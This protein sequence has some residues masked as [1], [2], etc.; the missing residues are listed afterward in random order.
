MAPPAKR[1]RGLTLPGYKYLGPG[2]SL[3]QGEP[4]NPSDAAA[5]EHDE[6]YDKYIKS[7]KNPYFYFSAADEKFIKETEHAK[8]YGGKI[9]H[10][11]FRAKRA[12]APK[13]SETDSPT[14]S[15]Q[16]E[17]RRSPRK[18]PGSKPP[19]KRPAPRHIFINLA[20]K[21]AKGTSNTN[22]N[23]MSENVEQHNPINAGTELSATGNESGGGGGGGGG[24]GAG[25]VGVS[26]G[27]FNNQT[28]FQY[29]VEGLVRITAHASRLI[30]LNMPEHET[31]KRI[32]V[33]NSESGV[34]GQM[35]QDDAHT[36]MVTPWS[37]ID[38]NAWGVWFNPADWQLISNNMTEINLVSFEQEIFNV[39]LKTITESAT[40][41][42]TKIYNNDLT[43]SLM[44][45]LD[46]NNT[47]PYT[48][49]APRS[50]TLGFYPWLPTKPTQYRYY[51]SC[52][53][54]LNPPTYT[55][56]SQQI[57]DSI[58]TGLHSDI[59]FYT[60]E[61]AVPIHLLRT[62]DEFSTGIYHFDTKPLK[63]THSW[64][65]NRSLGLPPKLL[66]EPTTEG[67][68][69]P[70]TLPAA[71]TRKGYHQTI[72]NSYTEATAIR[73][74][75]VGYNT[76]YM[77]FEYS[78][79]GPFL[80]P[81]VP[82]ADTQYNDDEPNGAIRFTMGYQ[83]GQLTT[84]S[85]ELERYTFNPQSKCGRAP[86]QQFNQQAPLNLENTNN[87]TLLPSDPIGGKP[88]MHFMNTLNTYGPL[89]A[90]NNT[91]PVF[92]N[93]Q[94]WDKEL[95]TDLK[96]RLHVTAPFVCK[97]NPPG[98]LFVKIAPNLTDDFN[99]DSPQQPRII[100]YSNFWWKGT[101]TF[102]AKMRS[103]N[104]WNPI[105]QHTTTAEN[106]GNYIPTNIGGIKMF[107]EYSQLIP[108]K[109]Y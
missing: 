84:S 106:I 40:S 24:R 72:N 97:N 86:K 37:L 18:H 60:I 14:T 3:D 65:T 87:G 5:K 44:V 45:A 48:P 4:T 88:N 80:T 89:T 33:L 78:N 16:P 13:L 83:H 91:A 58:Q 79:G 50:E 66:T 30:H 92:P 28:E 93:G 70:G 96:P 20:K 64:Q 81:I 99:A 63:L 102:T 55:G 29:L 6:A 7:G 17:V 2:N 107:P 62:G 85:Q 27:S 68:Q 57:T 75:Q 67:D 69:H 108:R 42:P 90:L 49:A 100:T 52:T 8:D 59:M 95:D 31:Y 76:P 94:I 11:F 39:V 19:G 1:A 98:Q 22:S 41:P 101:L 73:P 109:L 105:Q 21:K 51:L 15:Q 9:G 25:G 35:V 12:F 46:T 82:T 56:Q 32:H 47:L 43:A 26:T 61:N 71:N 38:A 53:R 74:A 77:N 10:Y 103:S 104:M 54:N 36:Q 34:A 23:S